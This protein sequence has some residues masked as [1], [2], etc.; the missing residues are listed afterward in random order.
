M[1][2]I[3]HFNHMPGPENILRKQLNNGSTVLVHEHPGTRTA[4]VNA[5]MPCGSYLDP[6]GK[7]GL[8]EFVASC[9][10]Y[11]TRSHDFSSLSE[12]LEGSGASIG[13]HCGPR[14]F[15]FNGACLAEDL[16][17]LLGILKEI[18]DEP[19]FPETQTEIHR[20]RMLS[21]YEMHLHDPES[22][23][24]ERFDE[25]LFGKNHPYGRTDYS[26]VEEIMSITRQ[27]LLDFQQRYLGPRGTIVTVSGG[28]PAEQIM[29]ECEKQLGSW[30]KSQEM[31][32]PSDYFPAV[33]FPEN[34]LSEHIEIP[35]KSEMSLLMGTLGPCRNAPDYLDAVLGNSILGE[36]GMMGRIGRKVREENGLAYYAGSS[37]TPLTYGGCWTVEAGV[38]PA[39]VESASGLITEELRR[40]TSEKVSD[41]ELDDVKSFFLGS[42]PLSLESNSGAA[43][44]LMNME[45]HDLGLDYLQQIPARVG[46]VTAES[47]L[48]TARKWLDPEKLIRVTAGTM[49][50]QKSEIRNR[51]IFKISQAGVWG[52]QSLRKTM[53]RASYFPGNK[54]SESRAITE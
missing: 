32:S 25:L 43:A 19:I 24:D 9:L 49:G 1:K 42:L 17:M 6:L 16:P 12:L 23:A 3:S 36:F 40:F 22:M 13:V 34:P 15:T 30:T 2:K 7:T 39:N 47:I 14:A 10:T 8:A 26:T 21:A 29:E 52:L 27:D 44:L 48:E 35:E 50:N 46:A 18:S 38:N 33:P 53:A 28:L 4:V 37:L 45:T 31:L 20:Q 51:G 11:G 54:I 41:E 5:S